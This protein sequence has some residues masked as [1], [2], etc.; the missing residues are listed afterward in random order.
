MKPHYNSD[1]GKKCH[2]FDKD[3]LFILLMIMKHGGRWDNLGRVFKIK[4]CTFEGMIT[5]SIGMISNH[6]YKLLL[7]DIVHEF[8]MR[9]LGITHPR[10]ETSQRLCMQLTLCFSNRIAQM[11]RYQKESFTSVGNTIVWCESGSF[12]I[13]ERTCYSVL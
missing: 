11:V 9:D 13:A 6:L 1:R 10:S 3:M 5:K 4:G 12:C 2:V 8:S 7:T